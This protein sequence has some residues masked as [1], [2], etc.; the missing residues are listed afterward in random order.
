MTFYASAGQQYITI[1]DGIR[2]PCQVSAVLHQDEWKVREIYRDR[3]THAI[4]HPQPLE[5]PAAEL[6]SAGTK[7]H[8]SKETQAMPRT[9]SQRG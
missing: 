9:S 4:A 1:R 2:R 8:L 3:E 7:L 6:A 5:T